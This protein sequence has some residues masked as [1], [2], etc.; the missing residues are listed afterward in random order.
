MSR[1]L[2]NFARP[3]QVLHGTTPLFDALK[4]LV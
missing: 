2:L 3:T 1:G 4:P